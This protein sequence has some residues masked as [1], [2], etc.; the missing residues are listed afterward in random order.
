MGQG[1]HLQ[2][3][4]LAF[5]APRLQENQGNPHADS[6]RCTTGCTENGHAS[7]DFTLAAF[8]AALTPEQRRRLLDL[9]TN[10]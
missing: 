9:L 5:E 2:L 3:G 1:P 10:G 6:A 8:V 7:N 4:K